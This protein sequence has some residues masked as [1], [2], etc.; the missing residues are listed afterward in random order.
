MHEH[1]IGPFRVTAD[2]AATAEIP[3]YRESGSTRFSSVN[4]WF[5]LTIFNVGARNVSLR[6]ADTCQTKQT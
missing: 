5:S 3:M 2:N 4:I 1:R 6:P